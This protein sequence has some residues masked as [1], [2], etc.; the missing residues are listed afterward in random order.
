MVPD[1]PEPAFPDAAPRRGLWTRPDFLKLWVGQTISEL[2]SRISR[3]GIPLTAVLVLHSGALE[4]GFLSAFGASAVL[5]FGLVAGVWVDRVRRRPILIAA[6]VGRALI[7]ASIP[8]AAMQG[9]LSMAQL[10]AV[11]ALTGV[12]TVVFDVAYPSYLP[13]LVERD[14]ILDGNSKLAL[15]GSAAEIVGPGLT[16]TLV[17]LI[18]APVAILFDAVSFLVSALTLGLIRKAEPPP[19]AR[20]P[21][22][23]WTE[24]L[25]GFRFIAGDPVLR[26]LALRAVT[27]YLFHSCLGPLYILY[28]LQVLHLRPAPLGLIIGL[29]GV[30]AL[31]GAFLAPRSERWLGRGALFLLSSALVGLAML[32]IPMAGFLPAPAVAFLVA[33]QLLGDSAFAVYAI[34]EVSLRQTVTPEGVLGRVNAAMQLLTRGV[35]PVGAL[36]GGTLASQIG[37]RPTLTVAALGILLST[38]WL[39]APS[40]RRLR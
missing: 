39:L 21:E 28:A 36:L 19:V 8:L 25:A 22:H 20:E 15:S 16:G 32:F 6:D 7:L 33:Q 3:E 4:M 5:A 14:Q 27:A 13:S 26:P 34:H 40:L 23:L 17:Q 10:Y 30:G 12:L 18:T 1:R 31:A 11:V 35:W 9:R 38:L 24:A 29:G 2:G 37:I